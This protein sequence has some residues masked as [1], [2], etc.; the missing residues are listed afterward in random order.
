MHEKEI[1]ELKRIVNAIFLVNLDS[2]SRERNIVDARKI[3]AKMLRD[4]GFSYEAIGKTI[5]K[6]HATIVHYI[7]NVEYILSYDKRL[8][9]KYIACKNDF[10][11][12]RESISEQI[13][14]DADV[15]VT[16]IRL[17]NELEEAISDKNKVLYDFVNY[18]EQYEHREGTLP[19]LYEYKH[20]ILPLFIK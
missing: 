9:D 20:T 17:A 14:K 3:Y 18:I 8:R 11:K 12:K 2:K 15:Y 5:G 10:I 16:I 1:Q 7:N 6:C 13:K 19:S 4:S